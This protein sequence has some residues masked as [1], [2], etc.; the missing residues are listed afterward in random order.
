M[1][2]GFILV[3]K[4][5]DVESSERWG[6]HVW[7]TEYVQVFIDLSSRMSGV[8]ASAFKKEESGEISR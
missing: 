3:M 6:G 1:A 7:Q 8:T 2:S 4:G 5:K